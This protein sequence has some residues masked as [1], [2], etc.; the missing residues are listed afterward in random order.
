MTDE[1][2]MPT[3]LDALVEYSAAVA[4]PWAVNWYLGAQ[5]AAGD[6]DAEEWSQWREEAL[7]DLGDDATEADI[8]AFQR[9]LL[10][11]ARSETNNVALLEVI[12]T[13]RSL[14]D[15]LEEG[16]YPAEVHRPASRA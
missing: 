14:A 1:F 15:R 2:S 6:P 5:F 11:E 9:R 10:R 3:D 4:I 7:R 8:D 12:D 16:Q 13:L